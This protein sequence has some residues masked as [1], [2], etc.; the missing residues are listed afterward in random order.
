VLGDEK[1]V[2][3]YIDDI[4]LHS[5]EFDGHLATLDSILRKLT[6]QMYTKMKICEVFEMWLK[7][8][9]LIIIIFT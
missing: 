9:F 1:N 2:I 8:V 4:V 3:T 5:S 6:F 7:K